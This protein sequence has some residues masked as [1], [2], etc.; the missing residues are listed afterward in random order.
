MAAPV[1]IDPES[2]VEQSETRHGYAAFLE[3]PRRAPRREARE[4]RRR[5]FGIWERLEARAQTQEERGRLEMRRERL[6]ELVRV[7][8]EPANDV[9]RPAPIVDE[10]AWLDRLYASC[11]G[12]DPDAA[13][14]LVLSTIDDLLHDRDAE[15]CDRILAM[16]DVTRL[17]V[18]AMIALLMETARASRAL[19][20]REGL[21]RRIDAEL[22]R[23]NE[24]DVDALLADLL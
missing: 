9:E 2:I 16:A 3:N 24:P 11:R 19:P 17:S 4:L 6:L 13:I 22:R 8:T 14:D 5:V 18:E 10:A 7:M 20:S 12:E 15:R 21:F 1:R 23:R